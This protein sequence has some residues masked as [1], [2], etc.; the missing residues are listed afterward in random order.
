MEIDQGI[1]WE[2]PSLQESKNLKKLDI[3]KT[4]QLWRNN[5]FHH[6]VQVIKLFVKVL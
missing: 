3:I 5:V 1:V 6:A 4:V 2:I